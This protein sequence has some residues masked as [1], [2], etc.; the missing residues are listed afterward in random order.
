M[1]TPIQL[2]PQDK[3]NLK[4]EENVHPRDWTNPTPS[5]RYNLVI[6]GAG[7]AGLVTAAGAAGLGA[8]VALVERE[9]MGGDCLNVGCV[10]SKALISAARTARAVRYADELGVQVPDGTTVDFA[11]VMQRMRQLRAEI[12]PNDSAARFRDLGIDVY[13]GQ[14][15]FIGSNTVQVGD[16]RLDFKRAVIATGARAS[17][18]P[19]PGLDQVDY[20]T[21][22]SIFSLTE[23][24][25]R[26]GIIGAGPIGCELAQTF[27][28]LGSEVFLVE[29][30]HG[31]LPRE[32]PDAAKI[33]EASVVRDCA[34]DGTPS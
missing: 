25:R 27:A 1:S 12:S 22:E 5:A 20:L 16:Q 8:K 15:T 13:L 7:T 29:A 17:A 26:L 4:L 31:I 24:P 18:P 3:H 33:V 9:L 32:D 10:P 19:I 34:A 21:N 23:L 6:I 11:R 2:Q 30:T 28:L 14:G